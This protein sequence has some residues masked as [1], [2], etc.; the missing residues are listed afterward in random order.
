M[1][2]KICGITNL[3]DA[4]AAAD[5]GATAIG[6]NF[7]RDSPRYVSP[8]GA[9]MIAAKLPEGVWKVGIFVDESADKVARVALEAGLDVAQLYGVS[10]ARGIRVW[11]ASRA[12]D[13]LL[14]A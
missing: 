7:Y 1:I 14:S 12:D 9:S 2:V 11:R 4:M 5:A 8:T 13:D 10:D 6:F 3:E